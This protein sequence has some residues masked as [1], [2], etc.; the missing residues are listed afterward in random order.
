MT[1]AVLRMRRAAKVKL[2]VLELP[3]A[4]WKIVLFLA[5]AVMFFAVLFYAWQVNSLTRGGYIV[6]DYQKQIKKISGENK[7]LQVSF[8]ESSFMGKAMA[9]AQEMN[10]EKT[11]SIKYIKILDNTPTAYQK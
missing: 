4:N 5:V 9:R 11:T 2:A 7:D 10:F 1:T 6:E 8:A 3:H